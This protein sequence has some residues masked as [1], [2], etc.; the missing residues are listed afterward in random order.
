MSNSKVKRRLI[1]AVVC[2]VLVF[3]IG[4]SQSTKVQDHETALDSV[5]IAPTDWD[6]LKSIEM[7]DDDCVPGPKSESCGSSFPKPKTTSEARRIIVSDECNGKTKVLA[8]YKTM[9]S[10]DRQISERFRCG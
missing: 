1:P 3:S 6:S 9:L 7:S 5:V 8:A 4:A 10:G 2:G